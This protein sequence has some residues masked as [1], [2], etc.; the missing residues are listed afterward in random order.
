MLCAINKEGTVELF[1]NPFAESKQING[2]IKSSRKNLTRKASA[3]VRLINPDTKNKSVPIISAFLQGPD[4]IIVSP[5]GGVD[6]S[7]QK[8]RWQDEGNGELLFDGVKNVIK[9]RSAST[10]NTATLNGVKDLGKT[11]VDESRTVVVNG[12][13]G[14]PSVA[15]AIEISSSESEGED[16][17]DTADEAEVK[18]EDPDSDSDEDEASDA[19][20]SDEEMADAGVATP[21]GDS[22]EP[23][24]QAEPSF[25]DLLAARHP[26]EIS[27]S[28]T[29][30][31][32]AIST[33]LSLPSKPTKSVFNL[34]PGMSL[35]TVL[36]QALRTNDTPLLESCLHTLD[37]SVVK[38]TIQRLDSSLAG[39]LLSKLAERLASRPGRYGHLITWVQWICIVH[40]GALASQPGTVK[41]LRTLYEVLGQRS[42]TMD[43]LLLLKG[44]L[45]LLDAQLQ[46]RKTLAAQREGGEG[47]GK[48]EPGVIYIEG[49]KGGWDS[50]EDGDEDDDDDLD[51][52]IA[53][54][55]KKARREGK[56]LDDVLS[57]SEEDSEA[58]QEDEDEDMPLANGA[59]LS[60]EDESEND[61]EDLP[62]GN[63]LIEDAASVTSADSD[64]D[65]LG[66]SPIASS[67]GASSSASGSDNEDEEEEEDDQQDSELDAFINDGDVDFEDA[68]DEIHVEGDSSAAEEETQ[69]VEIIPVEKE[70]AKAKV[71]KVL[72]SGVAGE[73]TEKGGKRDKKRSKH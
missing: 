35:G 65:D 43:D 51:E 30:P 18:A 45:D 29:L 71:K 73:K 63:P 5:D 33:S 15:D 26:T 19:S 7:F 66:P 17:E 44:K 8:L 25:G 58:S 21:A 69:E 4:L 47:Q 6:V 36:T 2:D 54:P 40:G 20:K 50:E 70:K 3:T 41:Q 46:F 62:N 34:S 42:R 31:T 60:S 14:G 57:E 13:A 64:P 22:A 67:S 59:D 56:D 27:I 61:S 37:I 32:T 23:T 55:N 1:P 48:G 39:L 28:A 68:E 10:L 11:S 53:R 49:Q 12:G 38:A 52:D 16:D 24:E 9:V 72:A